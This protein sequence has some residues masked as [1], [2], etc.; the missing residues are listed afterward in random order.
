MKSHG[1]KIP[2]CFLLLALLLMPLQLVTAS[3]KNI[4]SSRHGMMASTHCNYQR[5]ES[6]SAEKIQCC[7]QHDSSCMKLNH[8]SMGA[9][10][11]AF[12]SF[13]NEISIPVLSQFYFSENSELTGIAS[14]NQFHPPVSF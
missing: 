14:D 12:V 1:H 2:L 10:V 4:D 3:V 6:A 5:M 13:S 9:S 11:V 8:C 7:N